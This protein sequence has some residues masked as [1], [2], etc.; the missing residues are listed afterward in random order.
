MDTTGL[1]YR[2]NFCV[3]FD[4]F[5]SSSHE[6]R[7]ELFIKE[8]QRFASLWNVWTFVNYNTTEPE[9]V[10]IKAFFNLPI[11][12]YSDFDTVKGCISE[13]DSETYLTNDE[14]SNSAVCFILLF[15]Y[16]SH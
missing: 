15:V 6:M 4:L 11:T 1:T 16:R 10:G 9:A 3:V 13:D 2:F 12:H 5:A 7:V 8:V 14:D